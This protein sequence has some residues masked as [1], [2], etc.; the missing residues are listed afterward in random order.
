MR[1]PWSSILR[2]KFSYH[3]LNGKQEVYQ[4]AVLSSIE[5]KIVEIDYEAEVL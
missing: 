4:Q 2:Q 1:P 3:R 5:P